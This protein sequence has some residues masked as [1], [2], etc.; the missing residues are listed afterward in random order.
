[1]KERERRANRNR[2]RNRNRM[3]GRYWSQSNSDRHDQRYVN[4]SVA[5][6]ME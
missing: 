1:M 5:E 4:M 6:F 3:N 2:N